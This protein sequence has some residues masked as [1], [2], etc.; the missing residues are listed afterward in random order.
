MER[1][2]RNSHALIESDRQETP[3]LTSERIQ[4]HSRGGPPTGREV[5]PV[6]SVLWEFGG[7]GGSGL[8]PM[9]TVVGGGAPADPPAGRLPAPT[10]A[11]P[12]LSRSPCWRRATRS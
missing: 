8:R 7:Q 11:R 12:Y 6:D 2:Q 5:S 4:R 1:D 9:G 3:A 10:P